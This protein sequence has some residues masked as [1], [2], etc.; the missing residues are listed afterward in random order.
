MQRMALL[1]ALLLLS[2]LAVVLAVMLGRPAPSG[3]AG[4]IPPEEAQPLSRANR[5]LTLF[6]SVAPQAF[7]LRR[8]AGELRHEHGLEEVKDPEFTESLQEAGGIFPG[9]PEPDP[10]AEF[11]NRIEFLV[12]TTAVDRRAIQAR[13]KSLESPPGNDRLDGDAHGGGEFHAPGSGPVGFG[14]VTRRGGGDRLEFGFGARVRGGVVA[15]RRE[16]DAGEQERSEPCE[17]HGW[18]VATHAVRQGI[19]ISRSSRPASTA[20]ATTVSVPSTAT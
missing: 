20:R 5:K 1:I 3:G 16:Q 17:P 2:S 8:I 12:E 18:I 19:Q 14:V 13:A 15:A 4:A 9:H 11:R 10:T 7:L 6:V